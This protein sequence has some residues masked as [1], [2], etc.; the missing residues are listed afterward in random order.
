MSYNVVTETLVGPSAGVWTWTSHES[1][2][3]FDNFYAGN[4]TD[5]EGGPVR[6]VYKIIAEGCTEEQAIK[7][8]S[9]LRNDVAVI[10]SIL[11]EFCDAAKKI[12]EIY[13]PVGGN[14][15]QN[16]SRKFG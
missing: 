8:C 16:N 3:S 12:D 7:L 4:M 10:K 2:E 11:N 9:S 15:K 13:G 1:K 5:E 6:N 14:K